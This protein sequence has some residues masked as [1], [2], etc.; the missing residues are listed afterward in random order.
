MTGMYEAAKELARAHYDR[1]EGLHEYDAK[2]PTAGRIYAESQYL[3]YGAL[4]VVTRCINAVEAGFV[5]SASSRLAI[6][7]IDDRAKGV[8]DIWRK[9]GDVYET[10]QPVS[11]DQRIM[12]QGDLI[13]LGEIHCLPNLR[14]DEVEYDEDTRKLSVPIKKMAQIFSGEGRG[15]SR[16]SEVGG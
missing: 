15:L 2:S 8:L 13:H 14:D 3:Y 5:G 16:G 4:H 12:L 7:K 1:G 11:R 10:I 9:N 6:S